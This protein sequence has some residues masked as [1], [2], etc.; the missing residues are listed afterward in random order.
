VDLFFTREMS[1]HLTA[2]EKTENILFFNSAALPLA[3]KQ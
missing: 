1:A 3:V 2:E